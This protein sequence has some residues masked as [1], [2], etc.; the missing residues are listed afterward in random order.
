[1]KRIT[2]YNQFRES[3]VNEEFIGKMWRN[4]TGKTRVRIETMT[5][6]LNSL[7]DFATPI[8]IQEV[9]Y[10]KLEKGDEQLVKEVI[11]EFNKIVERGSWRQQLASYLDKEVVCN[12]SG[13]KSTIKLIGSFL[14]GETDFSAVEETDDSTFKN[15][16]ILFDSDVERIKKSLR[17]KRRDIAENY[18]KQALTTISNREEFQ[19]AKAKEGDILEPETKLL[20]YYSEV[21][22]WV[23]DDSEPIDVNKKVEEN[24]MNESIS[25][26][27]KSCVAFQNKPYK[28]G[29]YDKGNPEIYEESLGKDYIQNI[30]FTKKISDIENLKTLKSELEEVVKWTKESIIDKEKSIKSIDRLRTLYNAFEKQSKEVGIDKFYIKSY[31]FNLARSQSFLNL[32]NYILENYGQMTIKEFFDP[33]NSKINKGEFFTTTEDYFNGCEIYKVKQGSNK[34]Y[35]GGKI[36]PTDLDFLFREQGGMYAAKSMTAANNWPTILGTKES[37][38]GILS[39]G[40]TRRVYEITIKPG[41]KA[42]NI[43]PGGSDGGSKGGLKDENRHYTPLGI[44]VMAQKWYMQTPDGQIPEDLESK[45]K[46]TTKTPKDDYFSYVGE[47]EVVVFD[48]KVCDIR[49]V[50]FK[51][52]ISEYDRLGVEDRNRKKIKQLYPRMRD[53]VWSIESQSPGVLSNLKEFTD[54]QSSSLKE[55]GKLCRYLHFGKV[56]EIKAPNDQEVDDLVEK[57]GTISVN[58]TEIKKFATLLD[59][60]IYKREN[61]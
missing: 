42:I 56:E 33:S 8:T 17:F 3:R 22:D 58:D 46:G 5:K 41:T 18:L 20:K 16:M 32:V 61:Q 40:I 7:K 38:S 12:S 52:L 2:T 39:I 29:N 53:I 31:N 11:S 6:M 28:K 19:N 4:I 50:P 45:Y 1:M 10:I 9:P 27:L 15:D 21:F 36:S 51:E 48:R 35:H 60:I 59:Y 47:S 26:F 14:M 30:D 23:R 55:I 25:K 34:V 54:I 24:N 44:M 37:G 49:I 43:N 13:K 57:C